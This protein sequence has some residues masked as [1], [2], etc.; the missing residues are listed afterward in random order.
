[1]TEPKKSV[2]ITGQKELEGEHD[3]SYRYLLMP[4]IRF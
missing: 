2:V 3:D 4:I 1:M